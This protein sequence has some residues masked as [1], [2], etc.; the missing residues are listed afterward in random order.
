MKL[1]LL[2]P[3]DDLPRG[4]NPWEPWFDKCFGFVVRAG[5]ESQARQFAHEEAGKE[6]YNT[7]INRTISNTTSPWLDPKYSICTELTTDGEVGVI[8]RDFASA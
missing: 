7:F 6:N 2:R 5:T 3:V 4:D 8:I 1:W